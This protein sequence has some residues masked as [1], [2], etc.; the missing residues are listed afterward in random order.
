VT[1]IMGPIKKSWNPSEVCFKP[2]LFQLNVPITR[3]C[4]E[5][6]DANHPEGATSKFFL[7]QGKPIYTIWNKDGKSV[8]YFFRSTHPKNKNTV[9][10]WIRVQK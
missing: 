1:H 4:I 7:I 9:E 6:Y 5:Q 3:T 2:Q 8:D 10:V